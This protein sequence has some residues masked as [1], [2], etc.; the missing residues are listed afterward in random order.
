MDRGKLFVERL[1]RLL[2][3]CQAYCDRN[4]VQVRP[5]TT[6]PQTLFSRQPF[7]NA[8]GMP[9]LTMELGG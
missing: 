5:G 8:V 4:S 7:Q 3:T 1:Q 2:V 9:S 6:A